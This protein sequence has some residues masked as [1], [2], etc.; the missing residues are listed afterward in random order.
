MGYILKERTFEGLKSTLSLFFS[1]NDTCLNTLPHYYV[2]YFALFFK[3]LFT[4]YN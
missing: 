2:K 3:I 1:Y 4:L